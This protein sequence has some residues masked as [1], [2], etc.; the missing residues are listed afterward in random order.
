MRFIFKLILLL[1]FG[2]PFALAAVIFLVVDTRPTINRTAEVTPSSIA[3]A[4]RILDR[5]DPRKLTSGE[6]RTVSVTAVDL[7]LAANYLAQ[8]YAGGSARLQLR[9]GSA[10]VAASLRV[11]RLPLGLYLNVD[12]TLAE[13]ARIPRFES[14]RIGKL[15]IPSW[16]AHWIIANGPGLIRTDLELGA[17]NKIV[18]NVAITERG[19]ALT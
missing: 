3:R 8:Q 14:L 10:Q 15:P 16:L 9:N 17:L 18:Q 11:P 5:N 6:R 13:Q 19:V 1:L 12:A 2:L 7:D 4:K